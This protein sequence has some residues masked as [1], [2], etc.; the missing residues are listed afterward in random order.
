M[1]WCGVRFRVVLSGL[2]V[3]GIGL[4]CVGELVGL[5]FALFVIWLVS[6]GWWA[7]FAWI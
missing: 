2:G 1:G 7:G 4:R 5:R 3:V 6:S